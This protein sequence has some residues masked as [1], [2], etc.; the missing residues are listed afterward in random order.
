MEIL[1]KIAL[2]ASLILTLSSVKAQTTGEMQAAF[3][4]SYSAELKANY[5]LAIS[6]LTPVYKENNYELNLRMGWLYY[7]N[8][9]Y[10]ASQ[11][12]YQ[13]AVKLLPNSIEAKFGNTKPLSALQSWDKVLEQY[14]DILK[15]DGQNTQANYW[16]GSIQYNRKKYDLAAKLFERIVSL[17]PFD[18][19]GNHMLGW[20][21]LMLG[22]KAEA[23][24]LFNRTLLIKPAD[25][26]A[27]D[28]LNKTK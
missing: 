10:T 21:Y 12:Y 15:I 26:S 13:K 28:G 6:S 9:N 3:S 5:N 20:T 11:G 2:G 24:N 17:Y 4:A 23:K 22:R 14:N 18:Y 27:T 16:A 19:D 25:S 1:K 7:N 8:K